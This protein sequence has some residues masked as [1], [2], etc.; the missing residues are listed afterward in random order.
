MELDLREK[1]SEHEEFG[2]RGGLFCVGLVRTSQTN[3]IM[4]G[5]KF[6]SELMSLNMN[7]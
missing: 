5:F 6:N 1:G 7:K 4:L 3:V 2:R